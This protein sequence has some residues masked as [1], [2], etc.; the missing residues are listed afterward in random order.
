[1]LRL[2]RAIG[3]AFPLMTPLD[4]ITC[5]FRVGVL[6]DVV[7]LDGNCLRNIKEHVASDKYVQGIGLVFL[8]ISPRETNIY[9]SFC[10]WVLLMTELLFHRCFLIQYITMKKNSH[11]SGA[12]GGQPL[13]TKNS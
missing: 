6:D 10:S 2:C 7:V 8:N 12:M 1:M 3:K 11:L 9:N 13:G 4:L 5:T